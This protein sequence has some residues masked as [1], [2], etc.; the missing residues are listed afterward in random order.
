MNASANAPAP[1]ADNADA[2]MP[3]AFIGEVEQFND[4]SHGE[5][6][7]IQQDQQQADNRNDDDTDSRPLPFVGDD[8]RGAFYRRMREKAQARNAAPQ[9]EDIDTQSAVAPFAGVEGQQQEEHVETIDDVL[10]A[11][12]EQ[13]GGQQRPAPQTQSA[14]EKTYELKVNRNT[15]TAT[16]SQLLDM[17]GINEDEA[18][19][20]PDSALVRAAQFTEAARQ[21][22][23]EAK[24]SPVSAPADRQE[25]QP[26]PA[27]GNGHNAD[28]KQPSAPE[29]LSALPDTELVRLIQYGDEEEAAR[30]LRE[31]SRRAMREDQQQQRVSQV[32]MTVDQ[33]LQQFESTNSDL[34]QNPEAMELLTA[35]AVANVRSAMVNAGADPNLVA[36]LSQENVV[37][38]YSRAM[39]N[40]APL[41]PVGEILSAAEAKAR[42]IF[43][44]PKNTAAPQV[45][46]TP[47]QQPQPS[48]FDR[49]MAAKAALPQTPQRAGNPAPTVSQTPTR[50]TD[51]LSTRNWMRQQ[52]G[53]PPLP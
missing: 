48:A 49:R 26:H 46:P 29:S 45:R 20:M 31:S 25:Q 53:Q 14:P 4:P 34:A 33:A 52:R 11:Q 15:F 50:D 18:Q 39:A 23:M 28:G 40:G 38:V 22:L 17:A 3:D 12:A 27:D 16:R 6:P 8:E 24:S 21:R 2:V 13:A 5:A 32:R 30:A 36:S 47:Q 7:P 19:G 37:A 51:R 1:A 35:S 44:L 42:R 41:P 43:N 10:R 9:G